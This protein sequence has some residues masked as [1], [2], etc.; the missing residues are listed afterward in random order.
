MG[1]A[2]TDGRPADAADRVG[3]AT[4][5]SVTG[6]RRDRLGG[7]PGGRSD[8]TTTSNRS[9]THRRSGGGATPGRRRAGSSGTMRIATI[10][11]LVTAGAM[12]PVMSPVTPPLIPTAVAQGLRA[13]QQQPGVQESIPD[14][15]KN[16]GFDQRLGEQVPLDLAF[17][18]EAGN[19]VT[20][21]DYFGKRPVILS[22]VYYECP[23]L[24]TLVL[25]GLAGALK[26]VPFEMGESYDVLTVSFDPD[27]TPRLASAKKA[28]YLDSF[29]F[30][31]R[32]DAW[33]FLVGDQE[34]IRALTE[35]VGF[36]YAYDEETDQ[37]AHAS[38][39]MVLTPEGKVSRYFFGVEYSP[40][41]LRL[42]L[43]EASENQI[44]SVVDQVLLYCFQYNPA[45]G[46]Y[47]ATA[48]G[49]VRVAG[50]VTVIALLLFMIR[51]VRRDRRRASS[52][53][54]VAP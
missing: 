22:L 17:T 30:E 6:E 40:R 27:D 7:L 38:G 14:A 52:S 31:D 16:V 46:T 29:G 37:F 34:P 45:S 4:T 35:A 9:S 28:K 1:G 20:L 50:I 3:V 42:G 26:G 32:G 5:G 21:G 53:T 47:A 36:R 48:L 10:A 51:S 18:D 2:V 8:M 15:L 44:G 13:S 23:M 25:N 24:C 12:L 19:T 54:G 11:L 41:D 33:H 49:L 43:V 39:I